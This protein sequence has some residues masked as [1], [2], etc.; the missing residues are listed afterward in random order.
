MKYADINLEYS[1]SRI[2]VGYAIKSFWAKWSYPKIPEKTIV[3]HKKLKNLKWA[4]LHQYIKIH[5]ISHH[6]LP[7][8][9]SE[10]IDFHPHKE[11]ESEGKEFTRL[12]YGNPFI[13]LLYALLFVFTP[14]VKFG[15]RT[16]Y[17]LPKILL[18]IIV[19]LWLVIK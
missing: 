14:T 11:V 4:R 6:K 10:L 15:G 13:E 3:L 9:L 5:E 19:L 17:L 7:S 2:A 8:P 12:L 16:Y 1:D 18:Y